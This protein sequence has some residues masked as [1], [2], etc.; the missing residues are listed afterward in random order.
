MHSSETSSTV[1]HDL[2]PSDWVIRFGVSVPSGGRV[3]DVACGAGRHA[4]WFVGR[5]HVVNAVDKEKSPKLSAQ[6]AFK[7]ADIEICRWPYADE[8]F[9]AVVVTN[10]LHRALLKTLVNSVAAHGWL[11]YETFAEGNEQ[12]GRPSRSDFLL[13]P[14]ELL[15]AVHGKLRVVAYEHRYVD[16]PKPAMVQRIAAQNLID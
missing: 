16:K 12:F 5:G 8:L 7:Q 6:I 9:A 4:N 1:P 14:G 13:R 11:I 3:L 10:Y 2:A 15:D